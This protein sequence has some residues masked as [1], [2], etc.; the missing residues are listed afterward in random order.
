MNN[1]DQ[2]TVLRALEDARRILGEYIGRI[3]EEV[4]QRPRY[5][6]DAA[7][8]FEPSPDGVRSLPRPNEATIAPPK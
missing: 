3:Y 5:I 2:D 8:G 4:R 7:H 6:V 1:P